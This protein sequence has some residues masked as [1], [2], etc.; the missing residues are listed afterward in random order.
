[1]PVPRLFGP[2]GIRGVVGKDINV[3]FAYRVGST[4]GILFPRGPVAIGRDG[5]VSS[6]MLQEAVIAGILSQGPSVEDLG[7]IPTPAIE[8]LVKQ[9]RAAGGVM[10]TASHNPPEYNGFKIID[11]DGIEIPRLKEERVERLVHRDKWKLKK[12]P[13]NRL[14]PEGALQPYFSNVNSQIQNNPRPLE[15]YKVIVDSGNGV[16]ILT[17]PVLLKTLGCHVLTINDNIDGT[18]PARVS[19]PRPETLTVLSSL[20]KSEKADVGIA[21]D[22]DGDRAIFADETGTV[23][24]G[25]RTFAIIEDE[26]LKEKPGSKIVTP[27]NTSMAVT[28]IAKKR[29]GKL[30]LT[31]VGSIEVSRTMIR[32]NAVLGGEENGG[33]FYGPHHPVRDGTMAAVLVLKAMAKNKKPLSKLLARLPRFSMAKEKFVAKTEASKNR[34]M[35]TLKSKLG[36][37]ITSRLDGVKVDVKGKGWVLV[38]PSGTEPLIRLYVEGRTERDLSDLVEEFKPLVA[39]A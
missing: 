36:E 7:V 17:T 19:E 11:S 29:H 6:R 5:R 10:I 3:K 20:V 14:T 37:R 39:K 25:D 8:Y 26:V 18:F 31:R 13:G 35:A 15:G 28:E 4:I 34:A 24:W 9:R 32:T 1:M 38:R 21:H 30:I 16:S 27:L 2:N 23:H 33:I 22:G 12:I